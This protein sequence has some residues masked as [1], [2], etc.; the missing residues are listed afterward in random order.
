MATGEAAGEGEEEADARNSRKEV[1]QGEAA[2]SK[3]WQ[4]Q[5][6]A[7]VQVRQAHVVASFYGVVI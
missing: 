2:R 3:Q 1:R 4:A 5:Q 6:R 7:E